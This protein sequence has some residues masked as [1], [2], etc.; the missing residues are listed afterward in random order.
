MSKELEAFNIV[1]EMFNQ[2]AD[3][4]N[5]IGEF[6]KF[7]NACQD[8]EKALK[9]KEEIDTILNTGGGI[10]A[11]N[12][13]VAKKLKALD[14]IKTKKVDTEK[15]WLVENAYAYNNFGKVHVIP[16]TDEEFDL[17]KKVLL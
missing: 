13:I 7:T 1:V 11:E 9:D 2:Y 15:L 3:K 5:H 16:L 8:V 12:G 10:W 6:L 14:I 17:V 4:P